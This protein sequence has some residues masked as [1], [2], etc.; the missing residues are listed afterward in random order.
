MTQCLALR[1]LDADD[2]RGADDERDR[3]DGYRQ[4]EP[5]APATCEAG[6]EGHP[7][8]ACGDE[9]GERQPHEDRGA[10]DLRVEL[11]A[12]TGDVENRKGNSRGRQED[13]REANGQAQPVACY[14][15]PDRG[16]DGRRDEPA[17]ALSQQCQLEQQAGARQRRRPDVPVDDGDEARNRQMKKPSIQKAAVL[18]T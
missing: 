9:S 10:L 17:A 7:G 16:R 4:Q 5:W 18:F 14:R 1:R 13:E 8:E 3:D 2:G 15:E 6:L 12:A 11:A